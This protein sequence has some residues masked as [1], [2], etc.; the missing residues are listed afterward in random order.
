MYLSLPPLLRIESARLNLLSSQC[1]KT[2][3]LVVKQDLRDPD[4]FKAYG[5]LWTYFSFSNYLFIQISKREDAS[6]KIKRILA[7]FDQ[8]QA[9]NEFSMDVYTK[10][11]APTFRDMQ[12][13]M[14]KLI[15]DKNTPTHVRAIFS[16]LDTPLDDLLD[17]AEKK[18]DRPTTFSHS[19]PMCK[20]I[21]S[22]YKDILT[23]K[24]SNPVFYSA[25]EIVAL[26]EFFGEFAQIEDFKANEDSD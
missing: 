23:I 19:I 9:E 17:L 11:T 3:E 2:R 15:N 14:N 21:R 20:L 12:S 24:A 8:I 5:Q 7:I 13:L 26:N 25:M 16:K 18:G 1:Q 4:T 6:V 22:Y 10:V